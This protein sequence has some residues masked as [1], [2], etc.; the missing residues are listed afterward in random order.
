M[1]R[2]TFWRILA[3]RKRR[4]PTQVMILDAA[5]A[6]ALA[7]PLAVHAFDMFDRDPESVVAFVLACPS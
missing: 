7:F 5:V 1:M 4:I 6:I 2:R 3:R